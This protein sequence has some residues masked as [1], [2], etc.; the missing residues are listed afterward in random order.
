MRLRPYTL[1]QSESHPEN[2]RWRD[3]ADRKLPP[4]V[5][6]ESAVSDFNQRNNRTASLRRFHPKHLRVE[7]S[8]G[9]AIGSS[10][11]S[12]TLPGYSPSHDAAIVEVSIADSPM[13]GGGELLYLL[14]AG[15]AWRVVAKQGTWIS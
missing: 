15:Q 12:L 2:D 11:F 8:E 9:S 4:L 10:V 6:P 13:S 14:K 1:Q 5:V 7:W 3:L